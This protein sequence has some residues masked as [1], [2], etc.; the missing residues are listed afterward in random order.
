MFAVHQVEGQQRHARVSLEA[1][2]LHLY[3]L[4]EQPLPLGAGTLQVSW[5]LRPPP[6]RGGS[7][8]GP[9]GTLPPGTGHSQARESILVGEGKVWGVCSGWAWQWC[10]SLTR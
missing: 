4:K 10:M 3:A 9:D 6:D 1:G 2:R 8:A 5:G 7:H